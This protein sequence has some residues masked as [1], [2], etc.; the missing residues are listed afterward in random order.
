MLLGFYVKDVGS[1]QFMFFSHVHV[2]ASA[3][4]GNNSHR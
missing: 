4:Y 1:F 3:F 2:V